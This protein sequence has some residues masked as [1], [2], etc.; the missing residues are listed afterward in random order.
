MKKLLTLDVGTTSVKVSLFREDLTL[1]ASVINE[2]QLLTPKSDV[3]ELQP[4][5]YWENAVAGIRSVMGQTNTA[6]DEVACITCTTQGETLIPVG[7]NKQP[8]HN[9]IVWLDSRAKSEAGAIAEK[10]DQTAFYAKTGLPEVNAYCPISKLLWVKRNLPDVY[11]DTEKFLLVEDYLILRFTGKYAT[12]PGL[13]CSTGYFDIIGNKVWYEILTAFSLDTGK[14]PPVYPCAS[15]VGN[16]LP[17][18][19][20][21]LGLCTDTVVT[22]GAMDQIAAAV[23]SGNTETGTVQEST[24]TCIAIAA[25]IDKPDLSKWSP[26]TVHCHAIAG[27]YLD[28][29]VSQTAGIILKWFRNEFCQDIVSEHGEAAFEKMSELASLA[30]PLSKGLFLFPH[31]TGIQ[32]PQSNDDARGVFFGAG[33]D[34][35]RDCFIRSIME[36]VGY[37]LR[38]QVE[39]MHISPSHVIALGGGSKSDIWCQIK[40]SIL[41]TRIMVMDAEESASLGAAM[42]GGVACGL[43]ADLPSVAKVLSQKKIY[44][45]EEEDVKAY[46]KGYNRYRE[47]YDRFEPLFRPL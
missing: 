6:P 23:G 26:V 8:L 19:A 27:K 29:M 37:I 45:P 32:A 7:K 38:E 31:F 35:G 10:Y 3:V 2:Y 22:T 14:I 18:V 17:D 12:N 4:D 47:L 13:M 41:N 34:V 36:G 43:F 40:A 21:E 42:L 25:T 1:L 15:V 5:T 28:L 39:M 24:G 30:P 11:S 46:E 9:A 20:G 44:M 16:L 33:L